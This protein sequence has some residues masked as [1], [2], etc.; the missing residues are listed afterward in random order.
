MVSTFIDTLPSPFY[1]IVV[2]SVSA[3]F[4]DLVIIGERIEIGLKRGKFASNARQ[5]SFARKATQEKKKGDANAVIA[6]TMARYGQGKPMH[7]Q[8][9]E[10][11]GTIPTAPLYLPTNT[12]KA[13]TYTSTKPVN[14]RNTIRTL[15][16]VPVPYTELLKTLLERKLIT[17]VP[18][19]LAEPPYSKSYDRN[20]RCEYHGG[21]VGHST[22][23]C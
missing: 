7:I 22:D 14:R 19:K 5:V 4:A 2:G 15:D 20:S 12:A 23:K 21:V 3:N 16:P 1:E 10:R 8:V 17:I 13:N 18:L 6:N 9:K 11:P